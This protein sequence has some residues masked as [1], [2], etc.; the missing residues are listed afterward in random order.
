M[1]KKKEE[2]V[3]K[4]TET[5]EGEVVEV[6][7]EEVL[8]PVIEVAEESPKKPK[9]KVKK[10]VKKEFPNLFVEGKQVLRVT[11]L[12]GKKVVL[13]LEGVTYKFSDEEYKRN[14]K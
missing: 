7:T 11:E 10:V 6:T 14:V 5:P 12:D 2:V 3:T 1:P 4:V 8:E 13:T 9:K